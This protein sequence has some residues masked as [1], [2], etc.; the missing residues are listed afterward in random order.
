VPKVKTA[1]AVDQLWNSALIN[2]KDEVF[3]SG[4]AKNGEFSKVGGLGGLTTIP[5]TL[6]SVDSGFS[7]PAG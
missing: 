5:V 3:S 7:K 4:C 6:R 2:P 1:Q